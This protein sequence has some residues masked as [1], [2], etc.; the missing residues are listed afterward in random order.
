MNSLLPQASRM[1]RSRSSGFCSGAA[2]KPDGREPPDV[3]PSSW[4]RAGCAPRH[5]LGH[6]G[7]LGASG[8][9]ER[10]TAKGRPWENLKTC[11]TCQTPT[12]ALW[13]F[14]W[15]TPSPVKSRLADTGPATERPGTFQRPPLQLHSVL[16]SLAASSLS[17]L[18][19]ARLVHA[20]WPSLAL[21][22][23]N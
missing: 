12:T 4:L 1:N 13:R 5:V 9:S 22:H 14:S 18:R 6:L 17:L 10:Q 2:V 11:G 15:P 16:L 8:Q 20:S 21:T 7:S 3:R 23:C 19:S